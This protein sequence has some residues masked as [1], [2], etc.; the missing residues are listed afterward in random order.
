M[1]IGHFMP[2]HPVPALPHPSQLDTGLACC[3]AE[4]AN[5]EN[6]FS[7]LSAPQEGHFDGVSLFFRSRTSNCFPHFRQ[8]YS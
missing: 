5:E 7:G 2:P 4:T 8:L 3:G 1:L 6:I